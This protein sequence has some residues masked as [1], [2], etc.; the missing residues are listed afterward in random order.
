MNVEYRTDTDSLGEVSIPSDAYYGPFTG[1]AV[2][3]YSVTGAR[4]HDNLIRAFVMIKRSAAVANMKTGAMDAERGDAIVEACDQI[5]AGRFV[6][7]FVVDAINSGAGTAFNM[8][9]NEVIANVALEIMGKEK[10]QYQHLHPNDHVNMSQSSNDTFPTAMHVAIL[11]NLVQAVQAIDALIGSLSRKAEQ[12][13][14]CKKIGRTHLMDALP[15]TLGGEFAAYAT[16][17]TKARD[18]IAEA[19]KTLEPVALGATAVGTGANTPEGTERQ[20][21]QSWQR[22]RGFR[23]YRSRT[24]STR[25]RAGLPSQRHPRHC[26]TWRWSLAGSQTTSG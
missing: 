4:S 13:A 1:R 22:S 8:N 5:L 9:S 15:V 2:R 24:C 10:G 12:F 11:A 7:Q 14:P 6:D 3:Q 19:Q 21:S 18:A 26:G 20:Q 16:A 23:W 17:I 25:C